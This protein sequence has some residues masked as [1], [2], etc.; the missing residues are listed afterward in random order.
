MRVTKRYLEFPDGTHLRLPA[1][2]GK[3]A[4]PATI[5]RVRRHRQAASERAPQPG[6]KL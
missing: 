1:R 5:R 3:R 2:Q 4:S 6:G